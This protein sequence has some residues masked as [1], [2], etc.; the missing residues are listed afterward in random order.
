MKFEYYIWQPQMDGGH[1][2]KLNALGEEGWELVCCR[3]EK[4]IFR[5]A[6]KVHSFEN[7]YDFTHS[8]SIISCEVDAE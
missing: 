3:G 2:A 8:G 6:K 7:K 5:R 4:Y 1:N